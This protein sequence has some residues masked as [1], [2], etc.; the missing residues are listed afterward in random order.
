MHNRGGIRKY[1]V[2]LLKA[3]VDVGG[4]VYSGR[5]SPRFLHQLP[6]IMISYGPEEIQVISGSEVSPKQY[7]RRFRLNV[8][9]IAQ[10]TVEDE[11]S[12]PEANDSAEDTLDELAGATEIALSDD[13][14]LGKRLP[15]WNP[16]KGNGL[17]LGLRIM[18]T[19]PYNI[20]NGE[21]PRMIAHRLTIEVPYETDAYLDKKYRN[22][23]EYRVDINRPG[24]TGSTVDPTLLSAEGNL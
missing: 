7:E 19:D 12:D 16:E 11:G 24:Y 3:G 20:N 8:D 2:D 18:S 13:W 17:S 1:L 4:R 6:C 5:P 23:A 10:S 21:E 14:T 15:N 22:F 9:I